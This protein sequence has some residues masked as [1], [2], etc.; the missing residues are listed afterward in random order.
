MTRAARLTIL[1]GVGA[2]VAIAL[3]VDFAGARFGE[4][5]D[6]LASVG[7]GTLALACLAS[8]VQIAISARKWQMVLASI[9][10]EPTK[11]PGLRLSL[12]LAGLAAV[13]AQFLPLVVATP[14]LRSLAARYATGMSIVDGALA[15]VIEQAFDVL[16]FLLLFVPT[17]FVFSLA[18]AGVG[19]GFATWIAVAA[20]AGGS[21]F[22]LLGAGPE[23][24]LGRLVRRVLRAERWAAVLQAIAG[25]DVRLQRRMLCLSLLRNGAILARVMIIAAAAGFTLPVVHLVYGHTIV[26]ASQ[27][28]AITPGNLG[29]AEWT[30]VG[31]LGY[32]GHE[33]AM[34]AIFALTLRM[35]SIVSYILVAGLTTAFYTEPW[36][37]TRLAGR[38]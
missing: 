10:A 31:A 29:L 8:L 1:S 18:L 27:L 11:Q 2:A 14:V 22:L 9:S 7:L 15:S 21:V 35:V 30:W 33:T 28:A 6:R 3:L 19:V 37:R 5:A 26:Q 25:I 20:L 13:A 24:I 23:R 16:A 34:V 38:E 32:L 36:V 17:L 12:L 4:L